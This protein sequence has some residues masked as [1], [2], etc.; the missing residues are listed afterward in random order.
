[1]IQI[2]R[3]VKPTFNWLFNEDVLIKVVE[4][5][6]G[7]HHFYSIENFHWSIKFVQSNENW[8]IVAK[9][10]N[11][12][13]GLSSEICSLTAVFWTVNRAQKWDD[14]A[15]SGKNWSS[16]CES[17][18]AQDLA[19][20]S[21]VPINCKIYSSK[22]S[23]SCSV[24]STKHSIP[25]LA[26]SRIFN[27]K[28]C[29][30]LI[31]L[32]DIKSQCPWFHKIKVK[33]PKMTTLNSMSR[34]AGNE[35]SKILKTCLFLDVFPGDADVFLNHHRNSTPRRERPYSKLWFC[36]VENLRENGKNSDFLE[37]QA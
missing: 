16:F 17:L 14:W 9:I 5:P 7:S 15:S 27:L 4:G 24:F 37:I 25:T 21:L 22:N 1:M 12:H 26:L 10:R 36:P 33:E 35:P 34:S 3:D 20:L 29:N 18:Q 2:S 23:A 28:F 11:Q 31:S 8:R 13:L 30:F 6:L 19:H 32:K